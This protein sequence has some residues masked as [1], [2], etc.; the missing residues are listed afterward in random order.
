MANVGRSEVRT[1]KATC[2]ENDGCANQ[3]AN[4]IKLLKFTGFMAFNSDCAQIAYA[5]E[6]EDASMDDKRLK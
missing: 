1:E 3:I 2:T 4:A 6:T 5:E